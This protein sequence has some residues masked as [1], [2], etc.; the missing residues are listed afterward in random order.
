MLVDKQCDQILQRFTTVV[1]FGHFC[2]VK[3]Y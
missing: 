2:S 3:E 1:K